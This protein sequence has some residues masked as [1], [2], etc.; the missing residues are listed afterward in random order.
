MPIA[1]IIHNRFVSLIFRKIEMK[2]R[3]QQ[4]FVDNLNENNPIQERKCVIA[5]PLY[6]DN[7]IYRRIVDI[8]FC[9]IILDKHKVGIELVNCNNPKEFYGGV[10]IKDEKVSIAISDFYQKIREKGSENTDIIKE[11]KVE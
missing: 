6:P 4:K 10:F 8:H 9:V 5:N 1:E 2:D 7:S 11:Q 3:I